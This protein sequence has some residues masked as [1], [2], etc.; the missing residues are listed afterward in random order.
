MSKTKLLVADS[1]IIFQLGIREALKQ[2]TD[3]QIV[4]MCSSGKEALDGANKLIPGIVILEDKITECGCFDFI[5]NLREISPETKVI[6][7][8]SRHVD[9]EDAI[10]LLNLEVD[11]YLTDDID[12]LHLIDHIRDV[13]AD[14]R[15]MSPAMGIR[16]LDTYLSSKRRNNTVSKIKLTTR[17]EEILSLISKGLSNREISEKLYISINTVKAHT[18][19]IMKKIGAQN[20]Y[21]AAVFAKENG[22]IPR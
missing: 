9:D 2:A 16:L 20:R 8:T 18:S 7:V 3:I 15:A 19:D 22:I 14:K 13:V 21:R 1:R 10:N 11:G 5:M 12:P 6:I 17:E 4:S